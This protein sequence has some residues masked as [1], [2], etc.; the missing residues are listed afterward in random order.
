MN[1]TYNK[2]GFTLIEILVVIAIIAILVAFI[3]SNFL[4]ARQRAK[5][6]KIKSEFRGM[7]TALRLFYNDYNIYPGPAAT[8]TINTFSGCGV[9][10]PPST[11]CLTQATCPG[12]FAA[13]ASCVNVYVKLLP[14]ASDYAWSYRQVSSG[15]D[16]CLWASLENS[17]D[18]EVAKS[19][20][21]CDVICPSSIVP[22]TDYVVCAD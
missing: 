19:H 20:L 4:G 21:R 10:S 9:G 7:K 13:G 11:D 2:K 22:T 17:S 3:S 16:F 5:D 18:H 1:Y 8:T 14:P 15:N 12:M 6:V